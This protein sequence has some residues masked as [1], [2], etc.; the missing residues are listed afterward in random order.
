M[1]KK[2]SYLYELVESRWNELD[3]LEDKQA[4]QH[5]PSPVTRKMKKVG[6]RANRTLLAL[7]DVH[8]KAWDI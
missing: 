8:H 4:N 5:S 1:T 7:I 3:N 2:V 6:G